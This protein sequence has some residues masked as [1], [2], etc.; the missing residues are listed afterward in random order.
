VYKV[1]DAEK[2]FANLK[3]VHSFGVHSYSPGE[4]IDQR[5]LIERIHDFKAHLWWLVRRF[6]RGQLPTMRATASARARASW[7]NAAVWWAC[8]SLRGFRC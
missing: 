5:A 8:R 1:R 3:D 4:Q 7:A 6:F 2:F